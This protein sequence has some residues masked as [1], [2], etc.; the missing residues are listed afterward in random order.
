MNINNYLLFLGVP[1]L[2]TEDWNLVIFCAF[3]K[4]YVILPDTVLMSIPIWTEN[5]NY[6]YDH[7]CTN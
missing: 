5:L 1:N 6:W 3:E 4:S 7:E 2:K